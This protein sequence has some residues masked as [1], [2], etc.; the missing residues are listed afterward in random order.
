M[1]YISAA[2]K[3]VADARVGDTVTLSDRPAAEALPG[4]RKA[5]PMVFCGIFPADGAQYQ[6][7]REA[8]ERLQMC[9]RD[10]W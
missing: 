9:I 6:D 2:I 8:L 3:A 4:Y 7:L 5:N 1:G 10:R